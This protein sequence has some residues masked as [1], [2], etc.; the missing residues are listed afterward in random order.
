V[1]ERESNGM[2]FDAGIARLCAGSRHGGG[3]C[4]NATSR[5]ER[6]DVAPRLFDD[7]APGARWC[8]NAIM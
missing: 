4:A 7:Q 3:R 8:A 6:R 5:A 2:R 1:R